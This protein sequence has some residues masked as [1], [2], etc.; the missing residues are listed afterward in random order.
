MKIRELRMDFE[1]ET[2]VSVWAICS[3]QDDCDA[4]IAWLQLAKSNMKQWDKINAKAS[5]APKAPPSKNE[6]TE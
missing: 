3:T 2:A 1:K 5:R 6:N 4:L